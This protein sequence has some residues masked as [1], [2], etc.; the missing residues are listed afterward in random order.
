M[1]RSFRLKCNF[2]NENIL[3]PIYY[4]YN[5]TAL[6][7]SLTCKKYLARCIDIKMSWNINI[8]CSDVDVWSKIQLHSE[9]LGISVSKVEIIKF[10]T[11]LLL[12][13]ES[14]LNYKKSVNLIK[15]MNQL[16]SR[17]DINRFAALGKV[18]VNKVRAVVQ[19]RWRRQ[20]WKRWRRSVPAVEWEESVHQDSVTVG[21][22]FMWIH[23]VIMQPGNASFSV[24]R[25]MR[26]GG[27]CRL[28]S[29][30]RSSGASASF[31]VSGAA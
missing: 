13:D 5:E 11:F 20:F 18:K 22:T 7:W 16:W 10:N 23:I 28:P 6:S 12:Q 24:G 15:K 25:F 19:Q 2:L 31:G 26:R 21:Q 9:T 4:N 29:P 14:N 1:T 3:E 30:F 27:A 17:K 8:I